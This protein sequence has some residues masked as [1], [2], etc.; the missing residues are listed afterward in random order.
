MFVQNL[1][2]EFYNVLVGK[3][4]LIIVNYD[5][6]AIC[7]SKILQSLFK[8]DHMLYSVVPIMGMAGLQR[9]Y[10]ENRDDVKYVILINCGGCVDIV[11]LLQPDEEVIFFVCDAHRPLDVCNIYSDKQVCIRLESIKI[12]INF[13]TK[14]FF[15]ALSCIL[16]RH[17]ILRLNH[18]PFASTHSR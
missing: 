2:E 1:K 14:F 15:I 3:R 5:I 13:Q 11:D 7:A 8:Y 16:L 9:A 6:D 18:S 10:T 4:I 12:F 17:R